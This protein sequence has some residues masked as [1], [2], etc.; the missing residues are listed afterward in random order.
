MVDFSNSRRAMVDSQLR[1]SG[2]MDQRLLQAFSSVPREMF[3]PDD[4]SAVAYVDGHQPLGVVGR[5]L[6]SPEHFG[7]MLQLI[8]PQPSDRALTIGA[9][10]GYGTAILASVCAGVV[11]VEPEKGLV[12][13]ANENLSRLQIANAIVQADNPASA[14][15]LFDVIV[16]EGAIDSEPGEFLER[17]TVGGRLVAPLLRGGV[18]TV[19]LYT[20]EAG[21]VMF[22]SAFDASIPRLWGRPVDDGFAF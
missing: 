1:P 15:G 8:K 6:L 5:F 2:V 12:R 7:R 22:T 16:F 3:V 20:R 18:A 13:Q 10:S 9:G 14:E 17:L 21:G 11:G 19:R 4:R